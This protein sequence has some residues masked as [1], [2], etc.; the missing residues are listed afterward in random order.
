MITPTLLDGKELDGTWPAWLNENLQ[1]HCDPEELLAILLQHG[2]SPQSIRVHMGVSFP[3]ASRLLGDGPQGPDG[4]DAIAIDYEALARVR[5]T[6]PDSGLNARQ[7]LTDRLQLY[8]LD[9]FMTASECVHLARI[10][11]RHLRPSTVTTGERDKD[12]RTSRTCDLGLITDP[13]VARIDE[14]IARTLG[15]GSAYSESIQAQR[16]DVGEEFKA[17]TD[18][19]EPGTGE[20]DAHAG[21]RGQRT[22]TFMIY[23]NERMQGGETKFEALGQSIIPKRGMAV[24]WNNL[25]PDGRPNNQTAHC[26][27]PVR[28][29]HKIIITKWFRD[30]GTG[31]MFRAAD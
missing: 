5:M 18:Y 16:Y 27:L 1:R 11:N 30:R 19:F 31:P 4:G 15:I 2:F 22:W 7:F 29:G 8:T 10:V 25:L 23:L 12:Y 21:G 20:Y 26:G 6:R 28:R 13:E 17:H 3:G 24:V 14:R 9:D